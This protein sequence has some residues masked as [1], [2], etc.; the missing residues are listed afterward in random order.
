[1]QRALA[2][3][4]AAAAAGEVP[5]GALLVRGG[6]VLGEGYNRPIAAQDPTAH[7]E[8][9][10]LRAAARRVGNYRLPGSTL[11][12]TLEP[13]PMC[14]GAL[15]QA[16]VARVV[17]AAPDPRAGAAGSA[18]DLLGTGR[19]NHHI[20]Y[21]GGVLAAE[22]AAR[23]RAFFRARRG[24]GAGIAGPETM[25]PSLGAG[26]DGPPT[27]ALEPLATS[28]P[29]L[30]VAAAVGEA[31]LRAGQRLAVAESCTGGWLAAVLTAVPGSSRWLE[32]GWV[33]YSNAAK[34]ADL[35]VPEGQIA[36]HGA[37]SASV[38]AALAAGARARSGADWAVALTGIAGPDGGTAEK[39]V[40]TVFLG[41]AGPVGVRA[42]RLPLLAGDRQAIRRQAV[43]AAL[44]ALLAALAGG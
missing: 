22:S 17:F 9:E 7:A 26:A 42:E 1:M 39:P 40:G 41:L 30:P 35:G 25:A 12:V 33:A 43:A 18:I 2:L 4:A 32:R 36:A 10:A 44:A 3:A 29:P 6:E 8:V 20:L 16:R 28:V 31:L 11:Y 38:A 23:L 24:A 14:A 15:I 37:V 5:V 13:C 27:L 19:L 21:T 34:C